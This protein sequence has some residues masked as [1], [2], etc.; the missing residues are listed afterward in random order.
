MPTFA[1]LVIDMQVHFQEAILPMLTE[2]NHTIETCHRHNVPVIYTQ[3]GHV[4]LAKDA[5]SLGRFWGPQ[6]LINYGSD[7]WALI[8]SLKI[9]DGCEV[10]TEKRTYDA[11]FETR[12]DGILQ[13][14]HVDTLI[15]SG[16]LTELCCETTAR[17]AFVRGYDVQFLSDGTGSYDSKRH[18]NTLE[19]IKYGFGKVISCQEIRTY[20]S[21]QND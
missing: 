21:K 17:S 7:D 18:D 14:L 4:D 5:A 6:N 1:L 9:C 16:V 8:P 10:L 19:N 12:L 2:L 13:K 15:I 11:F 3:H 20:V